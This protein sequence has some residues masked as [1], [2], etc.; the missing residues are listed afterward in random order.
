M[1]NELEQAKNVLGD[2]FSKMG[3]AAR[4]FNMK[5]SEIFLYPILKLYTN[6]NPS[7]NLEEHIDYEFLIAANPV[8]DKTNSHLNKIHL[9]DEHT[10]NLIIE[11]YKYWNEKLHNEKS[12][13]WKSFQDFL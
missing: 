9:S 7:F 6:I 5:E 2:Y 4:P 8:L 1:S 3:G 13:H 10:K 11:Y 12:Y